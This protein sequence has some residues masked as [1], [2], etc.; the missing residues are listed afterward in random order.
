MNAT[1]KSLF[2][3]IEIFRTGKK[4]IMRTIITQDHCD[5]KITTMIFIAMPKNL[6]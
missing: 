1:Q 5:T 3:L 6:L 2:N 4:P